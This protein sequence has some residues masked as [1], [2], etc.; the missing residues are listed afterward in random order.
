MRELVEYMLEEYPAAFY[1]V[2][3]LAG[4]TV[5]GLVSLLRAAF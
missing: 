3:F 1:A 2:C 4:I 5:M